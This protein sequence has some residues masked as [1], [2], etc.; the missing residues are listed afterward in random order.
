[1]G[2]DDRRLGELVKNVI[3][4]VGT[5]SLVSVTVLSSCDATAR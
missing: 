3:L 1:M 2:A 5:F 4:T